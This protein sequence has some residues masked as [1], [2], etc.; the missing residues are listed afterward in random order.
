[1]NQH[2]KLLLQEPE[3]QNF[4]LMVSYI[5]LHKAARYRTLKC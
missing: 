3:P 5:A 1:M 4:D 2:T